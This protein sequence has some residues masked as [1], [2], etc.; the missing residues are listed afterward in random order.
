MGTPLSMS[1]YGSRFSLDVTQS[2]S[3][4]EYV[5]SNMVFHGFYGGTSLQAE[6]LNELQENI[7]NQTSLL[8]TLSG[9]WL[10]YNADGENEN[11]DAYNEYGN[12]LIPVDPAGI[13][14]IADI[15][16][17]SSGW[18]LYTDPNTGYKHYI[19]SPNRTSSTENTHIDVVLEKKTIFSNNDVWSS[20][21]GDPNINSSTFDK[22][23]AH[24]I[25]IE[26]I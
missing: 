7:Q 11:I 15:E 26:D 8:N 2:I 5:Y 25:R 13:S 16:T 9:N 3:K 18:F 1:D 21:L 12:K 19:S 10:S 23:G 24:R 17:I 20:L 6:E 14:Y 4:T 22:T